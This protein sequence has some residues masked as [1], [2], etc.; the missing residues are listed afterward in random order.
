MKIKIN[1][2]EWNVVFADNTCKEDA[3]G[4][5]NYIDQ[6]ITIKNGLSDVGTERTIYHELA[7]AFI[8]SYGLS[9]AEFN[10]ELVCDFVSIYSD[11]IGYYAGCVLASRNEV[12]V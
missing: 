4:T 10:E 1:D 8:W 11:K 12:K 7:H 6:L 9:N 3:I 5:T 2:L